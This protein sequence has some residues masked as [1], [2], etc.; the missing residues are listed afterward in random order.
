MEDNL[1]PILLPIKSFEF[2]K[3]ISFIDVTG[4]VKVYDGYL[5]GLSTLHRTGQATFLQN[6]DVNPPTI[7]VK[8]TIGLRDLKGQYRAGAKF[9]NIGPQFKIELGVESVGIQFEILQKVVQGSKP[10]LLTFHVVDLTKVTAKVDNPISIFDWLIN[11]ITNF[12]IKW[13]KGVVMLVLEIPLKKLLQDI[14][15]NKDLPSLG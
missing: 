5:K 10:K 9:M 15:N 11:K 7:N 1:D 14:L 13:V 4:V 8:A 2:S 6:N 12:V 3:K